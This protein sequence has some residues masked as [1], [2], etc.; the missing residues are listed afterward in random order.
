[1]P[2]PD[3]GQASEQVF[4][5]LQRLQARD[6]GCNGYAVGDTAFPPQLAAT[7]RPEPV[8][9][10]AVVDAGHAAGAHPRQGLEVPPDRAGL[11]DEPRTR[12]PAAP[13]LMSGR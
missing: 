1:K 7:R 9:V 10:D 6:H 11:A 5:P 2:L 13:P 12:T 3:R 4:V 8:Q